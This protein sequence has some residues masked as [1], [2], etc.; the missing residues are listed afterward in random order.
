MK[1][2][3]KDVDK[4]LL[5]LIIFF[6]VLFI[7]FTAYYETALRK[8]LNIEGQNSKKLSEITAQSTMEKL[9]ATDNIKRYALMDKAVL[10]EKYNDLIIQHENLQKEKTKLEEELTLLKSQ[11]EYQQFK[12][13]GTA[14]QF[15]LIQDKNQQIRELK[16]RIG[17]LCSMLE[18]NKSSVRECG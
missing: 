7:F 15:K 16:N 17:A 18:Y 4:T 14:A 3:K 9:N 8:T 1:Y 5:V 11:T 13:E 2:I 6:L 10:E 12:I